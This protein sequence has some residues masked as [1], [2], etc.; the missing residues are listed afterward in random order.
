MSECMSQKKEMI[1]ALHDFTS[2]YVISEGYTQT[3]C[4]QAHCQRV[5]ELASWKR[6]STR[7]AVL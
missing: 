2:K 6:Q 3:P 5:V 4:V 1:L 7:M